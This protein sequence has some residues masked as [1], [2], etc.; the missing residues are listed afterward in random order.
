MHVRDPA[1]RACHFVHN[2]QDCAET[3][4]GVSPGESETH[5]RCVALAVA[6][7]DET[8]GD[9]AVRC[10][11]EIEVEVSMSGSR[12]RTRRADALVEF[13]EE[14]LF[15]G[16]GLVVEV[17]HH[18]HEKDLRMATH[19]YL[20]VGYSVIWLDTDAF[21]KH[22]L[23]VAVI[24][25]AF[26]DDDGEGYRADGTSPSGFIHCE[27]WMY[28]GEHNWGT[29]PGYVLTIEEGYEICTHPNCT[30]RR[31]YDEDQ[32]AYDY[33]PEAITP[34]D[35]PLR[36]L[37]NT[38]VDDPPTFSFEEWLNDRYGDA[39]LETALADRPEIDEC[40]GSKGF[41]EWQS[42]ETVVLRSQPEDYAPAL[43]ALLNSFTHGSTGLPKRPNGHLLRAGSRPRVESDGAVG[44]SA[45]V[46]TPV[47][48]GR[49]VGG[50]LPRLRPLLI[51]P[52]FCS[53]NAVGQWRLPGVG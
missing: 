27:S 38:L 37:R 7:L 50:P 24:E 53:S 18:H 8:Y 9:L 5:A 36:V 28:S 47:S 23:D 6:T 31:R 30:I 17:Q 41:H 29:V 45:T 35:L 48:R 12:Y 26:E 16:V 42:P 39:P 49:G 21:D 32:G 14:N 13:A 25:R 34:P 46:R 2:D 11:P 52:S 43:S 20:S 4:S 44:E 40:P 51:G 22:S 3:C 15:F 1:G 19:D 33:N 10:G